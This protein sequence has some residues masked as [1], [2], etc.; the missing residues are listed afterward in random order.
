[1]ATAN[2]GKIKPQSPVGSLDRY[3]YYYA[4]A[5]AGFYHAGPSWFGD[6]MDVDG[7]VTASTLS[8]G[9]VAVDDILISSDA[10][11]AADD[12]LVTAGYVDAHSGVG[13]VTGPGSSTDNNLATFDGAT[14]KIIQDA[15]GINA[16]GSGVLSGVLEVDTAASGGWDVSTASYDSK[17][18][19][20]LGNTF[21][22]I[23]MKADGTKVFVVAT[24]GSDP[25]TVLGFDLSTPWD[26]STMAADGNEYDASGEDTG[27]KDVAFNSDG[28]KMYLVGR[29]DDKVYQYSLSAAWDVSTASYDSV[30]HDISGEE[31]AAT[32]LAFNSDGTKM[33]TYGSSSGSVNQYSL[34][35]AWD[36]STASYDSKSF[37]PGTTNQSGLAFKSDGTKMY[38]GG[39]QESVQQYS[40]STAWDVST[41]SY[42][43][44]SFD[45]GE[46]GPIDIAF[47]G[48]GTKM[49]ISRR[50]PGDDRIR[51]Y[52][53]STADLV[54]KYNGT[55]VLTIGNAALTV[56]AAATF[57]LG[58]VAVD[59]ILISSDA[60]STADD[61]LVTAG[62]VDAHSGDVTGPGSSTDN[63]L[64]MFNGATG[65]IIQDASGINA[66]GSGVLSGVLEVDSGAASDL[67]LKYN[68]ND[69]LT[70]GA[71]TIQVGTDG[72]GR[73]LVL[74]A[75][76]GTNEGGEIV[77]NGAGAYSGTSVYIDRFQD[78]LR[79]V[80][81][82][83][84][85]LQVNTTRI[86]ADVPIRAK[87]YA[88]ASLPAGTAG[89][90]AYASDGRKAGEGAASGT[91]VLVFH[92]GSNW[93]AVD[94]G[95][96][97]AA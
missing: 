96:T 8:L 52:S 2:P 62:Y 83:T 85:P 77:F 69:A 14:G 29:T 82:G 33:Y 28:T 5:S 7:T 43:S 22:N 79:V 71:N 44:K 61:V 47:N 16:P 10:A 4:D 26:I 89:D 93:I 24:G 39:Y 78:T 81:T 32:A 25:D 9:G 92:D 19:P 45:P 76:G 73:R 74:A 41:A 30:S 91:G 21:N 27:I 37:D 58:G 59:D 56:V 87:S 42:D 57:S 68:G 6:D 1:M 48:D 50:D 72:G 31:T 64:A 12:V 53:L 46:D 36:L 15:S 90:T 23:F 88:V 55:T 18:G 34:S 13:D 95:A 49:Y 54:L 17:Q 65:K 97:V 86:A 75:V 63:N 51:Q 66:P 94:T 40:L 67:V 3:G 20:V 60:A 11:S 70:A 80:H 35:T 84:V 38:V